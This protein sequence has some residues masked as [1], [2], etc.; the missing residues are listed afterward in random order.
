MRIDKTYKCLTKDGYIAYCCGYKPRNME[1]LE[2][3][4]ILYPT[5][6]IRLKNNMTGEIDDTFT[7]KS[8]DEQENYSEIE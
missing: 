7:I 5:N 1:I 6:G 4:L 8:I 2:E 3:F